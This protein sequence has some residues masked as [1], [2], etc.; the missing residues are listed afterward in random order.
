[1]MEATVRAM[2]RDRD[3]DSES[4]RPGGNLC[5][6]PNATIHFNLWD[7]WDAVTVVD[8]AVFADCDWP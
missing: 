2:D 6:I 4:G 7:T 3:R 8:G 1:M 5:Y